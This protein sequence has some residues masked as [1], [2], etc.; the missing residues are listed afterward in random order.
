MNTLP[1]EL[2]NII[3]NYKQQLD[4]SE[5]YKKVLAEIKNNV[6]FEIDK[7]YDDMSQII[8]KK[9]NKNIIFY[10]HYHRYTLATF[11]NIY[12]KNNNKYYLGHSNHIWDDKWNN[13]YDDYFFKTPIGYLDDDEIKKYMNF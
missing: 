8:I 12:T 7:D 10:Y 11:T 6:K 13:G 2:V 4:T 5:K 9:N 3:T 1:P